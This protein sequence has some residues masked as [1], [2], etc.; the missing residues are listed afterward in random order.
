MDYFV[1]G[2]DGQQFG[3]ASIETLKAW[4]REQRVTPATMLR[5]VAT[6]ETVAA[7]TVSGIFPEP[8][9]AAAAPKTDLSGYYV[10]GQDGQQYGPAS[11]DTLKSWVRE[12][13]IAPGTMLRNAATGESVQAST[14]PGLFQNK[15]PVHAA[16]ANWSQPPTPYVRPNQIYSQDD[17]KSDII[18]A[19]VRSVLAVVFC[20]VLG[21]WGIFFA[22]YAVVFAFRAKSKGHRHA[23]IAIGISI[24]ALVLVVV[25]VAIRY[26]S[27]GSIY[28]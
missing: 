25:G 8:S 16:G 1:I 2:T 20:F 28:R 13:R 27:T 11:V 18:W 10:V 26:A 5:N 17:G 9:P 7:S 3:P 15:P 19:I 12:Q 14:V 4:A 22:I 24:T 23:A 21:G 6:G